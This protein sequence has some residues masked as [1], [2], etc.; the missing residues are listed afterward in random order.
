MI[1]RKRDVS[2]ETEVENR[3]AKVLWR[4][5]HFLRDHL[6]EQPP[7]QEWHLTRIVHRCLIIADTFA[8]KQIL[9]A[10]WVPDRLGLLG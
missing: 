1:R 6:K 4:T 10:Y 2:G 8:P 5:V 7:F 9:V 3:A